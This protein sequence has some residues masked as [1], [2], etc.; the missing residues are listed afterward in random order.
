MILTRER[1]SYSH[2]VPEKEESCGVQEKS[3]HWKKI[4][5]GGCALGILATAVYLVSSYYLSGENTCGT[6]IPLVSDSNSITS[7]SMTIDVCTEN[8]KN[9]VKKLNDC[10]VAKELIENVK[11][12]QAFCTDD[13]KIAPLGAANFPCSNALAINV[14]H[15]NDKKMGGDVLFE[16]INLSQRH[17]FVENG[18]AMCSMG[19]EAYVNAVEAIEYTTVQTYREITETCISNGFLSENWSRYVDSAWQSFQ[20][21]LSFNEQN[22]HTDI[23]RIHWYQACAPEKLPD[24]IAKMKPIWESQ[25]T[26]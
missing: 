4:A 11:G 13:P 19:R 6:Q 15:A 21:Y 16:L 25:I 26:S 1:S 24:W 5:L 2:P 8:L 7:T 10:P 17:R 22:G 23:L 9:I 18:K 12:V 20:S 3:F 14:N